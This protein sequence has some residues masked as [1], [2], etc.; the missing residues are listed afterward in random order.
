MVGYREGP[1]RCDDSTGPSALGLA[2]SF[3]GAH[4]SSAENGPEEGGRESKQPG[5]EGIQ[6]QV[7]R[8]GRWSGL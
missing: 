6:E 8:Q 2:P 3:L 4:R 7:S 5:A 1:L